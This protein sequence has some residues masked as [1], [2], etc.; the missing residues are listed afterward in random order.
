MIRSRPRRRISPSSAASSRASTPRRRE[1][2]GTPRSTVRDSPRRNRFPTR[3]RV[4][5][6]KRRYGPADHEPQCPKSPP[7]GSS[8]PIDPPQK[9]CRSSR[10]A[11]NAQRPQ[12][13]SLAGL[14]RPQLSRKRRRV[15]K[16][17]VDPG[18]LLRRRA[19]RGPTRTTPPGSRA[20]GISRK[21]GASLRSSDTVG[22]N[23]STQ[24]DPEHRGSRSRWL[25]SE[26]LRIRSP[27]HRAYDSD[28]AMTNK[29]V[30]R[31]KKHY[32]RRS[33]CI[34]SNWTRTQPSSPKHCR[35]RTFGCV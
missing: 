19:C 20:L 6:S 31:G 34:W 25:I 22:P 14:E 7:L 35:P 1:L 9:R 26:D 23:W 17:P 24:F 8:T 13:T 10:A 18:S 11:R 32:S 12:I 2:R 16:S 15:R 33:P 4:H 29:L 28:S 3:T 5:R 21:A 30:V 27:R